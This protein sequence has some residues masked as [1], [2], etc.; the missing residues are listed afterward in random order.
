M[1]SDIIHQQSH[2]STGHA[3]MQERQ[4]PLKFMQLQA[5]PSIG[6]WCSL[7]SA[8]V[9][10]VVAGAGPDWLLLDVEH[11]PNDLR[12]V[13]TQLQA[14]GQ[15]P[16]EPVVRLPCDSAVLIKQ[17]MDAGA[18]SLMIPNVTSA[19]QARE[20]V[21]AMRYPPQGVRGVS[22]AHRANRFGRIID[23]H[24]TAQTQQ[25]LAVQIETAPAVANA[26]EIAA[27]DGVDVLF[28]GPGDLSANLGAMGNPEAEHVQRAIREVLAAATAAGKSS[29]ILAPVRSHAQRYA[30]MGFSMLAVGSDLGVL[31]AGSDELVQAFGRHAQ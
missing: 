8:L 29:G 6:M 28:V 7:G 12:S 9:A 20:V 27:V 1:I 31:R 15:Y 11:G 10:E 23:Y 25:L 26:A 24:A 2:E 30:Q 14:L 16:L 4:N 19:R 13:V 18:R 22:A 5:W 17:F 21:A 3:P